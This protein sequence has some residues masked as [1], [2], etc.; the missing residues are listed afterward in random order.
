MKSEFID[1]AAARLQQSLWDVELTVHALLSEAAGELND[2]QRDPLENCRN[3]SIPVTLHD[4]C[5]CCSRFARRGRRDDCMT[6]R[7]DSGRNDQTTLLDL[8]RS[9]LGRRLAALNRGLLR[10]Q[11]RQPEPEERQNRQHQPEKDR[12][13]DESLTKTENRLR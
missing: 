6:G 5:P 1:T 12:D 9:A 11:S 8:H 10:R 3:L 4:G 7:K 13:I 2:N